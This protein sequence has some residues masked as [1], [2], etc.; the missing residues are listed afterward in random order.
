MNNTASKVL[1]SNN[2]LFYSFR[3]DTITPYQSQTFG[4]WIRC[5]DIP[6]IVISHDA[7]HDITM[8]RHVSSDITHTGSPR[9]TRQ[10]QVQRKTT[11]SLRFTR[12]FFGFASALILARLA[13]SVVLL[14]S[15]SWTH[16]RTD[17]TTSK[18]RPSPFRTRPGPWAHVCVW[19][20][21][22]LFSFLSF[23]VFL[24]PGTWYSLQ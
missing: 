3:R 8:Y 16:H 2:L 12:A 1:P 14:L 15:I 5:L 4:I 6:Y 9:N 24:I 22:H 18:Q 7:G 20:I 13:F 23:P 19:F 11:T 17:R 21:F 10:I